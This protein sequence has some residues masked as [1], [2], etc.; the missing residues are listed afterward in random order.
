MI[1]KISDTIKNEVQEYLNRLGDIAEVRKQE[2]GRFLETLEPS[3]QEQLNLAA[4]GDPK[5]LTNLDL[6]RGQ[7]GGKLAEIGLDEYHEQTQAV[8]SIVATALHVAI[9]M[10]L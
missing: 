5:A 10:M 6:L 1:D 3:I 4:Q 2:F 9:S 8:V 7:I